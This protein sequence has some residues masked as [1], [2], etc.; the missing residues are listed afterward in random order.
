MP[1]IQQLIS[2]E[3]KIQQIL[4]VLTTAHSSLANYQVVYNP[5]RHDHAGNMLLENEIV[6][7]SVNQTLRLCNTRFP[8]F[9]I[10]DIYL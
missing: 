7:L 8:I 2:A 9:G 5:P 6:P 10:F 4:K 1:Q 3:V